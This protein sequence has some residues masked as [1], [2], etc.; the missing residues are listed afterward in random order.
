MGNTSSQD[1]V[2]GFQ[3]A[4][5]IMS[6]I[7]FLGNAITMSNAATGAGTSV[8]GSVGSIGGSPGTL[9]LIGGGVLLIMILK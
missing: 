1:V 8:L 7:P 2:S 5:Q 9:L 3:S 6:S 4:N